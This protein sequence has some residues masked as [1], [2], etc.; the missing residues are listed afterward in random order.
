MIQSLSAIVVLSPEYNGSIP[1]DLKH[2]FDNLYHEWHGKPFVTVTYGVK[3]GL[4][5]ST[6][7]KQIFEVVKPDVISCGEVQITL[8]FNEYIMAQKQVQGDEA[9]LDEHKDI[10]AGICT[11]IVEKAS[12]ST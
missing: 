5:S 3:G 6:T 1:G 4:G 12:T 11:K 8:P 7:L 9:F 10:M 2:A